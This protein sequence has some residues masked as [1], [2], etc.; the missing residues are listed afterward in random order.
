MAGL[1]GFFKDAGVF[2]YL[3]V[4]FGLFSAALLIDRIKALYFDLPLKTD[5]FMNQVRGLIEQDKIEDAIT[6]CSANE[7]KPIAQVIKRLL[8]RSDRD[9]SSM[10]QAVDVGI[11]EVAPKIT[12]RLGHLAMVAN[13]ATLLG[14]LGTIE[15]LI[16]AFKAL[17]DAD[18]SQKQFLLAQGISMAMSDTALGLFVAIPTMVLYSFLNS[19]HNK[20]FSDIHEHTTKTVDLLKSRQFQPFSEKS[21]FPDK[22]NGMENT[23]LPDMPSPGRKTV[24]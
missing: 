7:K 24:A 1:M 8:E 16:T 15:G 14:L 12:Q 6:Y 22:M 11:S 17:S 13:V 18:P 2:G 5:V 20:I 10:H 9:E 19:K 23:K 21:A 3:I 4:G